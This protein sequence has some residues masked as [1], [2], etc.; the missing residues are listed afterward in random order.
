MKR[1]GIWA[2]GCAAVLATPAIEAKP[3]YDATITRT[4][5]GIPHIEARD[6]R[7]VGYGVAYAYA[8][9]NLC[10][11]AEEFTTVAGERSLHWGPAAKATRDHRSARPARGRQGHERARAGSDGGLC[12]GL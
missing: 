9:D 4:T 10:L 1:I 11:L 3:R 5:H 7:G 6:W 2:A 12:R 8:Q